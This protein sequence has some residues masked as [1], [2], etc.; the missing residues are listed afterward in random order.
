MTVAT[1]TVAGK[2]PQVVLLPVWSSSYLRMYSPN[3]Y[4][5]FLSFLL[6]WLFFIPLFFSTFGQFSSHVKYYLCRL[7]TPSVIFSCVCFTRRIV[8][9][10]YTLV[11]TEPREC[12][13][14]EDVSQRNMATSA[15]KTKVTV[16]HMSTNVVFSLDLVYEIPCLCC[17]NNHDKWATYVEGFNM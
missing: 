16:P 5:P 12:G 17:F 10:Y 1:V 4:L 15:W 13:H 8:W 9:C 2:Q 6:F 14:L 3:C 11:L 7:I